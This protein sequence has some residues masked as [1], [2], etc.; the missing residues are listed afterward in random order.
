MT[1]ATIMQQAAADGVTRT[2]SP[3]GNVNVSGDAVAVNGWLSVIREH[4]TRIVAALSVG[5]SDSSPIWGWLIHYTDRDPIESY[6]TPMVTHAQ[7]MA[8]RPEAI[9]AEPIPIT[10]ET[11]E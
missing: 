6:F 5:A 4:K 7:V 3:S 8:L 11:E 2:L 1:P 10:I 9:A